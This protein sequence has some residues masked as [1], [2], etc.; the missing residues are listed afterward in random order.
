M[1]FEL[2]EHFFRIGTQD[3]FRDNEAFFFILVQIALVP[4]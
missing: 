1:D 3:Y 4:L 2:F